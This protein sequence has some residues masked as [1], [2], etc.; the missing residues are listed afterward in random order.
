M[1]NTQNHEEKHM[2]FADKP[3]M[4]TPSFLQ[5]YRAFVYGGRKRETNINGNIKRAYDGIEPF[6]Y[7]T[8]QQKKEWK[9]G[10]EYARKERIE[11]RTKKEKEDIRD[12]MPRQHYEEKHREFVE[13]YR[14][15]PNYTNKYFAKVL[16]VSATFI[17]KCKMKLLKNN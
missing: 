12:V 14:K 1:I 9:Q 7:L 2:P 3:I 10:V 16:G 13:M 15:N 17:S 6:D 11:L 8:D 5:G 4:W